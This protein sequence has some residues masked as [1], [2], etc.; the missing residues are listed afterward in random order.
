MS[1]V[2]HISVVSDCL[3]ELLLAAERKRRYCIGPR[4]GKLHD[5]P[6]MLVT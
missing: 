6:S 4:E 3:P 1:L 5:S 2:V